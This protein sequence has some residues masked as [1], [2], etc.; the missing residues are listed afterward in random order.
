MLSLPAQYPLHCY[1]PYCYPW[2][3][4]CHCCIYMET[5]ST[6]VLMLVLFS[7]HYI[8]TTTPSASMLLSPPFMLLKWVHYHPHLFPE[9]IKFCPC[10]G[11]GE[12]FH[13][14]FSCRSV[15][16]LYSSLLDI[17]SDKVTLD[18]NMLWPI[19]KHWILKELDA[20]LIIAH[21]PCCL[22]FPSG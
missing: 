20:T 7:Q 13:H 19:M 16:Q 9:V 5:P 11:L 12:D 22:H 18:I 21:D 8:C 6:F 3:C 17:V 10:K 1:I 14:L 2:L 4:Y 15:A